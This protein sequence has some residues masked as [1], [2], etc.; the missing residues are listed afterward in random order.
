M[1]LFF[2]PHS[3]SVYSP[4]EGDDTGDGVEVTTWSGDPTTVLGMI[5]PISAQVAYQDYA[6]E[7]RRPLRLFAD[8]EAAASFPKGALVHCASR[9]EWAKVSAPAIVLDAIARISH[10]VVICEQCS[11]TGNPLE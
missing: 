4:I 7:I 5:E 6:L 3:F 1:A 9:S 11:P 2:K 10:C 8:A